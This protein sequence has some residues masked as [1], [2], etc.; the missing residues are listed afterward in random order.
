VAI[1]ADDFAA[2]GVS[3]AELEAATKTVR[4]NPPRPFPPEHFAA[5]QQALRAAKAKA[6]PPPAEE[7]APAERWQGGSVLEA[8]KRSPPNGEAH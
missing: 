3:L 4:R 1:W 7:V 2:A 8:F 5:L 6:P